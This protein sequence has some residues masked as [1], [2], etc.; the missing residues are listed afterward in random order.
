MFISKIVSFLLAILCTVSPLFSGI[1]EKEWFGEEKYTVEDAENILLDIAVISDTHSS[2]EFLSEQT[3]LLRRVICG[4]SH[5]ARIP[6]ALV[7]AG[8][9][10]NATDKKEYGRLAKTMEVYSD[11]ILLRAVNYL[12]MEQPAEF[13]YSVPLN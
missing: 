7:I 5:T 11:K 1:A 4:I 12:T 8:D 3:E 13:Q 6:D 9:I 10:S 2:S